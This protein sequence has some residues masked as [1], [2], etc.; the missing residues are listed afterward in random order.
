MLQAKIKSIRDQ[1][2]ILKDLTI[3]FGIQNEVC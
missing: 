1:M 2:M 3:N